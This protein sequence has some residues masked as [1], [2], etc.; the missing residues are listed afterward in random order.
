[1]TN[2]IYMRQYIRRFIIHLV[3]WICL[4]F[5]LVFYCRNL[6]E[7][8]N[9]EIELSSESGF[10][11]VPFYLEITSDFDKI[12]YTLDCSDPDENGILYNNPILISDA[13]NN[14]NVY[15][16]NKEICLD[17][18]NEYLQEYL[19]IDSYFGYRLPNKKVDKATV[20]R[21]IGVRENGEKSVIKNAIFFVGYENK[22]GYKNTNY[23]S[24]ITDP[25][26]LFDYND[27]IYILGK[28]FRNDYLKNV[29]ENTWIDP[30]VGWWPANYHMK[31]SRW[32]R[33]CDII[34]M[35]SKGD[36]L[37][38]GSYGIRIQGGASRGCANKSLNIF[39]RKQYGNYPLS[40][41]LSENNSI[42]SVNLY[43]GGSGDQ[44]S[45][46]RDYLINNIIAGLELPTRNFV[47]YQLFLDGEYWG[48]YWMTDRFNEE[49]FLNHYGIIPENL[50]MIK[51]WN[52]EIGSDEDIKM[53]RN[54][55]DYIASHD[56]SEIS[57]YS[58]AKKMIDIDNFINY[59]AVEI[60][61][62]NWDWPN[63]N[64]ISWRSI[65]PANEK[66]SDGLWRYIVY[67][68]NEGMKPGREEDDYIDYAA[69]RDDMFASLLMN[70]EFKMR[71]EERLVYLARNNFNPS[72]VDEMI[73]KY[74]FEMSDAS[75]HNLLRFFGD[76]KSY[77]DFISECECIR[78]YFYKRHDYIIETY[79]K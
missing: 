4:V 47:P 48:T 56:M 12:Y 19:G 31:H 76:S 35:N 21:A 6:D 71:L 30:N 45:H 69:D 49:Y 51:N 28:H 75:T 73:D 25:S 2:K 50:I 63:N 55:M 46:L 33:P 67:D 20:V 58:E 14:D 34:C 7:Q 32:E 66:Y 1:M 16:M 53:F 74:E 24:I 9:Q 22:T 44:I 26:N 40:V 62:A 3:L 79:E 29:D 70:D 61:I 23:I 8:N 65:Q 54:M 27:G 41:V 78:S 18:S 11:S 68:V 64:V 72:R 38:E 52:V 17:Y 13:S 10:Y 42:S 60:Y 15:S 59:Y 36:I 37:L 43:N 77:D 39:S 57:Q 5:S